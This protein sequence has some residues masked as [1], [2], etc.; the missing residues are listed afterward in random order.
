MRKKDKLN[1]YR[2]C[3]IC[4]AVGNWAEFI[5]A[6]LCHRNLRLEIKDKLKELKDLLKVTDTSLL[7]DIINALPKAK[8]LEIKKFLH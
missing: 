1:K 4:G 8:R 2:K 6:G 5:E 3:S 7:I